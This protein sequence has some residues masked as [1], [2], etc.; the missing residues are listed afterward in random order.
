M[1]LISGRSIRMAMYSLKPI[2]DADERKPRELR[3]LEPFAP[4]HIAS[5]VYDSQADLG[6]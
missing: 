6:L 1:V 5:T 2:F 4:S 3:L